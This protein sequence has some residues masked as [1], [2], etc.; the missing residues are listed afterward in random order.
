MDIVG[1]VLLVVVALGAAVLL[2]QRLGQQP[3]APAPRPWEAS[4][5][6]GAVVVLDLVPTD[7]EHP[8]VRRMVEEAARGP[9]ASDP[10]LEAVEVRDREDRVLGRVERPQPLPEISIPEELHQPRAPRPRVPDPLGRSGAPRPHPG[11]DDESVEVADR[12]FA[13]RFELDEDVRGAVRDHDDPVDLVRAILARGGHAPEVHGDL[14]TSDD[15]G[16]VVLP[17][18]G[19][20]LDAALSRAF[21][22]I[23]QA[24]V[25]RGVVI[26]LGWVNPET[27][28]RRELAA[29]HVRHVGAE[30]IQRM[31]DAV[32]LGADPV[33]FILGPAVVT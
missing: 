24:R 21:L 25:P 2:G 11:G 5:P 23:Q 13:D 31:A 33:G 26:H 7:P 29:P 12:L 15:V 18:A 8:S 16:I 6:G 30:A 10:Q 1:V 20:E 9:L 17:D 4:E 19:H 3:P 32:T 14:V 27:L 22:R 28:H